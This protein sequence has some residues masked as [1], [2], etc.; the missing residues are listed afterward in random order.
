MHL[1]VWLTAP[2]SLSSYRTRLTRPYGMCKA[3]AATVQVTNASVSVVTP[4]CQDRQVI[5]G[6]CECK[7][8]KLIDNTALYLEPANSLSRGDS[9][10]RV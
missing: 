5:A 4:S 6:C 2:M 3:A 7:A 10:S 1:A 9:Q 8:G